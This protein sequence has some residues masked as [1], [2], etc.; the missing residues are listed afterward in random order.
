MAIQVKQ[1]SG[2]TVELVFDPR[3]DDL[4]IG[5]NLSVAEDQGRRGLI[6]QIIEFR[7]ISLPFLLPGRL[8]L[9]DASLAS[10]LAPV[11]SLPPAA[12][13]SGEPLPRLNDVSPLQLAIAKIRRRAGPTWHQWDGW[14]PRPDAV[15]AK[16]A[17]REV[18][19]HCI[20]QAGNPLS[21]GKTRA[22]EDFYVEGRTLEKINLI[23][24]VKGSGPSHLAKIIL[25]EL[26]ACGA[27][28]VIFD[29]N[30]EYTRFAHDNIPAVA[31]REASRHLAHLVAGDTMK[32]GV[33]PF[34]LGSLQ[35]L[36]TD[37]GLPEAAAMY[38]VS[39]VAHSLA[40][41]KQQG[42]LCQSPPS[43]G[44]D[45]LIKMA[46][47]LEPV[48][49][50]VVSRTLLSCL[51]AIRET[52]VLATFASEALPFRQRYE[53]IRDGGA[54]A[55][56]LS[57]LTNRARPSF[58]HAVIEFLQEICDTERA[59]GSN[60]FPFVFF[61][62]AHL[63]INRH[64]VGDIV[65]RAKHRGVTSFLMTDMVTKLDEAVLRQAN[66]LF[67]LRLPYADDIRHL[68][69]S[70]L[71]DQD[72]MTCVVPRLPDHHSLLLGDATRAYPII[73]TFGVVDG[74]DAA[75]EIPYFFRSQ[76]TDVPSTRPA[77][78]PGQH[79]SPSPAAAPDSDATLPLFPEGIPPLVTPRPSAAHGLAFNTP[80]P[81]PPVIALA[82]VTSKW[83]QIV[84][85]LGRRRRI[86]ETI[87]SMARPLRIAGHT[88]V[89]GFPPQHRFQQELI[90]SADYR[91]L[92][93]EELASLFGVTFE[94]TTVLDPTQEPPRRR[95]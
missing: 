87:L 48:D 79:V 31:G 86:L 56:D 84:K 74:S 51:K 43:L 37:F 45:D 26:I 44:I 55:I 20:P 21:L 66:N 94:V 33:A 18:L 10:G 49:G 19:R 52:G 73:F 62:Q 65:I 69:Q 9:A 92:L 38:F 4:R 41:L 60:R 78:A 30:R 81:S 91:T 64:T 58:V 57:R 59:Q 61:D 47:D 63:Y 67:I 93:E 1:I 34:G 72:T 25:R 39:H 53:E 6:V 40:A 54:L 12:L 32:L 36:L 35:T 89:L 11:G 80:Q 46:H 77:D 29:L 22:G 90:E 71:I 13:R 27:P 50:E 5:E 2:D 68:S 8:P 14:I 23:T 70:G 28:C 85:R 7:M 15:V 88:L 75:D 82:Q 83:E 24:G 76:G 16:T 42:D 17:D 95:G 3:E